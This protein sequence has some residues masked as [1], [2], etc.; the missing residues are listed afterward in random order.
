MSTGTAKL[1]FCKYLLILTNANVAWM[2]WALLWVTVVSFLCII[3]RTPTWEIS[4]VTHITRS[5]I[6]KLKLTRLLLCFGYRKVFG[7]GHGR[8]G[9]QR[10][11]QPSARPWIGQ[12]GRSPL[13]LAPEARRLREDLAH[14]LVRPARRPAV[15]LQRW[16]R[17]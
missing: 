12:A 6:Y 1:M 9:W 11:Q 5:V 16:G 17:D 10:G 4:H 13:R 3:T 15:L 14:A 8:A 7:F 2:K